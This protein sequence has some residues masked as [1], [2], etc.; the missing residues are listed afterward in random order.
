MGA[1][2]TTRTQLHGASKSP[3]AKDP[4]G[5]AGVLS[6]PGGKAGLLTDPGG[7]AVVRIDP[8]AKAGVLTDQGAKERVLVKGRLKGGKA[9]QLSC[10]FRG[11]CPSA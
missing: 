3:P 6:A 11:E 5:N 2:M 8:G 10:K 1:L 7:G 9:P 4:V